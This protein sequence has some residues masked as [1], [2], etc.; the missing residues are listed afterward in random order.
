MSYDAATQYIVR[1]GEPGDVF[2]MITKGTV[3]VI[4][5]FTDPDTGTFAVFRGIR[6]F[7]LGGVFRAFCRTV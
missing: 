6:S 3:D 2:Y 7:L 4:Y 5:T 1:Q